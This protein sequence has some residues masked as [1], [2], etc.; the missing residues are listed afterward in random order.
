MWH[1]GLEAFFKTGFRNFHSLVSENTKTSFTFFLS[2]LGSTSTVLYFILD[3]SQLLLIAFWQYSMWSDSGMSNWNLKFCPVLGYDLTVD[4]FLT[5]NEVDLFCR[6]WQILHQKK[7]RIMQITAPWQLQIY[8]KMTLSWNI[9][10]K[11]I[12]MPLCCYKYIN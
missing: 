5:E 11:I 1:P 2:G 7:H 4:G 12:K 10:L 3:K 9:F 6:F 8:S